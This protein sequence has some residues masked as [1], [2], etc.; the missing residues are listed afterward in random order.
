MSSGVTELQWTAL[1]ASASFGTE[2]RKIWTQRSL[3]PRVASLSIL[4]AYHKTVLGVAW[5]FI[6]PLIV[7]GTATIVFRHALGVTGA[8]TSAPY[9]IFVLA[10]FA[11]W[12][13]FE[14]GVSWC[15]RC[16]VRHKAIARNFSTSRALLLFATSAPAIAESL[17]V[18]L[19]LLL[20][21]TGWAI[22]DGVWYL[23]LGWKALVLIPLLLVMLIAIW[24]ISLF[25]SI[26]YVR[27]RDTWY[28]LRYVLTA[29]LFL[30]PVFYSLDDLPPRMAYLVRLNPLA[31][32][33]A[34]YH[35]AILDGELPD[36]RIALLHLLLLLLIFVVALRFF[37]RNSFDVMDQV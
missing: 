11:A 33:F 16:L 5:L 21:A 29:S 24:S 37:L 18:F 28:V 9:P 22:A 3:L 31:S 1:P 14:R 17:A 7:A 26:L 34:V 25:T 32:Y 4:T 19:C 23:P 27:V 35:W 13:L 30:T 20:A 12:L 2:V 36:A 8:G 15:T 6:R 10:G